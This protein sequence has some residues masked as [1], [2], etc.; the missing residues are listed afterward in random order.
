MAAVFRAHDSVL[1]VDRA[2]KVLKP[3]R[4]VNPD[5]RHRF[6]K[7]AIAM[8]KINHLNVVQITAMKG[9]LATL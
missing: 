2:I 4:I 1:K 6:E 3:E 7:E 8:A 5:H 9:W